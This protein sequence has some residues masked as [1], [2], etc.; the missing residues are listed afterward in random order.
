MWTVKGPRVDA[1]QPHAAPQRP[2][3]RT[4]TRPRQHRRAVPSQRLSTSTAATPTAP[5]NSSAGSAT[6]A[7]STLGASP[8]TGPATTTTKTTTCPT[9]S[10]SAPLKKPSTAHA[11]STSTTPPPG[12][13]DYTDE[14][15]GGATSRAHAPAMRDLRPSLHVNI[16]RDAYPMYARYTRRACASSRCTRGRQTLPRDTVAS[17]SS[18][19]PMHHHTK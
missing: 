2:G 7:S 1:P 16:G 6:A 14:L 18:C 11:A 3:G 17:A 9:A 10:P 15:I 12:S 13:P 19:S 8:P 4:L 5:S